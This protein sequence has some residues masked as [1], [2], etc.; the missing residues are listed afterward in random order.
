MSAI[1]KLA[2]LFGAHPARAEARPPGYARVA[3]GR[4]PIAYQGFLDHLGPLYAGQVK[5][6][7]G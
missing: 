1:G 5:A 7:S 4:Y 3:V 2:L 6:L